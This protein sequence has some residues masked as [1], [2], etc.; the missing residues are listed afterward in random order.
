[1]INKSSESSLDNWEHRAFPSQKEADSYIEGLLTKDVEAPCE[2]I[3]SSDVIAIENS[4]QMHLAEGIT[5]FRNL[6]NK[7]GKTYKTNIATVMLD[8][9]DSQWHTFVKNGVTLS[10]GE[11][12]HD[13]IS[14]MNI[15]CCQAYINYSEWNGQQWIYRP[16]LGEIIAHPGHYFLSVGWT[17][18]KPPA[19]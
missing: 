7:Y 2:G 19:A 13:D 11:I 1:M 14:V 6:D 9:Q 10:P 3:E 8:L 15:Q 4:S 5:T 18:G 16:H 12:W 17:W